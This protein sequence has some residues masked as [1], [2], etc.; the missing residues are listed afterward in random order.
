M[1]L[2]DLTEFE[3]FK[4]QRSKTSGYKDLGIVK[5]SNSFELNLNLLIHVSLKSDCV[6]L[7]W[8]KLVIFNLA[9]YFK[10]QRSKELSLCHKLKFSNL[11]ICA[12]QIP[13]NPV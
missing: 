13:Q 3:S 7:T 10:C 11:F 4:Y 6:N 1:R 5:A 2:F 8:F 9:E 12:A